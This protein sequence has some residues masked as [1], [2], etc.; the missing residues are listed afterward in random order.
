[1]AILSASTAVLRYCMSLH[2]GGEEIPLTPT[3]VRHYQCTAYR[4][5]REIRHTV[6]QYRTSHR[7]APYAMSVPDIA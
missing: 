5:R 1:M 7:I 3:C 2:A 4:V 6:C